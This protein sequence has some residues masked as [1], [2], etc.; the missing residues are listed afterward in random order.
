MTY[1]LLYNLLRGLH[2]LADIAWM[3]GLL[4][5][6]RLFVYHVKAPAGSE[7]EATFKV[8]EA[9]LYGL[10]MTPAMVAAWTFGLALIVLDGAQRLG[11][12][13]LAAPWALTKLTGAVVL[14]AW[15]VFLGRSRRTFAAGLNERSERF[16]RAANEV[17]FVLAIIMVLAVTTKFG[18]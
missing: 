12:G 11:W 17:P 2:I 14:T 10:I 4:Y 7:M 13:F 18:G 16:W 6:P 8:M 15:H 5:L 1:F 3:A 9:K